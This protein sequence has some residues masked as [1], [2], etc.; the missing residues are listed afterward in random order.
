MADRLAGEV[1]VIRALMY[2]YLIDFWGDVPLVTHTLTIDELMVARTPKEE[3]IDFL[4]TDLEVAAA[5]LPVEIP[6][7]ENLGR[8]SRGAAL[9]LKARIALYHGRFDVAEDA[10]RRVMDLGVYS[11]FDIGNPDRN[12]Y[13]LFTDK[14]KLSAGLNKETI[15]GRLCLADVSMHNLSRE[16][17]VPDQFIRWNPTKHLVDVI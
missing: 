9:A 6:V 1:R 2:S 8:M 11:L 3:V 17:Q 16:I 7:G 15:I 4:M 12:Y 13:T 14:G 5:N 10:A